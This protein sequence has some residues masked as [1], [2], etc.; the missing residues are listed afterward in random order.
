MQAIFLALAI[1]FFPWERAP[2]PSRQPQG[3]ETRKSPEP[4]GVFAGS[5]CT[6]SRSL[7]R[8]IPIIS[9]I[10]WR[11]RLSRGLAVAVA[12]RFITTKTAGR[13][14]TRT[15]A[16]FIQTRPARQAGHEVRTRDA[17]CSM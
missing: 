6:I 17:A 4:I 9:A 2:S 7:S 5:P 15:V 13:H 10:T 16:G 8:A 1:I 14:L 3:T 12:C 11:E